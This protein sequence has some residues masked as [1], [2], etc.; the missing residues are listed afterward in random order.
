MWF[1]LI[2][3]SSTGHRCL[4]RVN[5]IPHRSHLP[6]SHV[7]RPHTCRA[8]SVKMSRKWEMKTDCLTRPLDV[9]PSASRS[10]SL[11][12]ITL[13]EATSSLP[14]SAPPPQ[15]GQCCLSFSAGDGFIRQNKKKSILLGLSSLLPAWA[16]GSVLSSCIQSRRPLVGLVPYSRA[17]VL[18]FLNDAFSS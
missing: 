4:I 13:R 2:L 16:P 8:R 5:D 17:S 11:E 6:L 9:C 18:L 12:I 14:K 10:L 7:R 15:P 3:P 1:L